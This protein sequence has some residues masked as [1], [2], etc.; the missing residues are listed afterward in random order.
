MKNLSQ[1]LSRIEALEKAL[2]ESNSVN[3]DFNKK[4]SSYEQRIEMFKAIISQAHNDNKF[5]MGCIN[6]IN[7]SKNKLK[8]RGDNLEIVCLILCASWLTYFWV[9]FFY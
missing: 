9:K 4:I 2:A 1:Y 8:K 6:D 3:N 5:Y 7:L